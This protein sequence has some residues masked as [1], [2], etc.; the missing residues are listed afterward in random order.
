LPFFSGLGQ[1]VSTVFLGE[2]QRTQADL[3]F[4]L[5]GFSVRVSV[6]FW[7][8][9]VMLG[10]G[11][12]QDL[13]KILIWVLAVFV[14]ILI[15][16]LGHAFAFRYFGVS[17]HIVL[18]HFGGLA[19]PDSAYSPWGRKTGAQDSRS[20]IIVSAAGPGIQLILFVCLIVGI[21]LAGH[22][23]PVWI[24]FLP[25]QLMTQIVGSG[26]SITNPHA[27]HLL[28]F[29]LQINLFWA[30]LNLAPIY[31]LDGGQIAREV[32]L[33]IDVRNGIRNSL[34]LSVGTG[35]AIGIYAALNKLPFLALM[36]GL[37]A[38]SSYQ[39]LQTY[40]G[41]GGGYGGGRPW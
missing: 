34:M 27:F 26:S 32:C 14:S 33:L 35:A 11:Y 1:G 23:V 6:F 2:P 31:P 5:F 40:S 7:L 17:C 3:N 19:V 4:P 38:Y 24:P 22:R 16:E 18:Y 37:L 29:L 20:K 10:W 15:H 13:S 21:L 25:D 30:V 9:A 41:R 36:F 12:A 39:A 28:A 8:T